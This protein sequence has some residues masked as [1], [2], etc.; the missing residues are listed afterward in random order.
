MTYTADIPISGESLGSTRDRIRGNFQENAAVFAINHV[1]FNT[2]GKGKHKFLQMPNQASAPA[3]LANEAG[4][5]SKVG[6]NPAESNLFFR[7]ENNGFE[8]QLTRANQANIATFSTAT[9]WT[10]LPGG[11][12]MQWGKQAGSSANT[13]PVTFP[14]MFTNPAY[15]VQVIPERAASNPG[16]STLTVIVTGSVSP[17]GFTIGNVGSHTMVNWYWIAIGK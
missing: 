12:I 9:G 4:F 7:G 8:Y 5:Y 10:Y 15:S 17:S 3:T 14:I 13:I 16:D 6:T 2:L 11:L 1:A